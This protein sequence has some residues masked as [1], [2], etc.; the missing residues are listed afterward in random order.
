MGSS[1]VNYYNNKVFFSSSTI[2]VRSKNASSTQNK[3]KLFLYQTYFKLRGEYTVSVP[4][5]S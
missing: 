5:V 1:S 2:F 3:K 4:H